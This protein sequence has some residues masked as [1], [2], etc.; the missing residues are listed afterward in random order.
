MSENSR[1]LVIIKLDEVREL[2]SLSRS[3]IYAKVK[4]GEFPAPVKLGCRASGWVK[5]EVMDW[6]EDR[7]TERR[8]A[9]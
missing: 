7:M 1:A 2:T 9:A 5:H 6:I 8:Q 4:H 3:G